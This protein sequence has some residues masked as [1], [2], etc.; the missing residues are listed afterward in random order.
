MAAQNKGARMSPHVVLNREVVKKVLETVDAGLV[1][2][3]GIPVPGK[4]CVEAAVNYALG[5]E[6]NDHPACVSASVR[7]FKIGLNDGPW[8]TDADR[9]NGMR[10]LA[11]AQLGSD[12][13]DQKQFRI[14][15]AIQ[16]VKRILP[17]AF[18]AAASLIP[19]HKNALEAAAVDC[20]VVV[21]L[22]AARAAAR[23]G[24]VVCGTARYDADAYADAY[25]AAAYAAAAAAYAAYAAADADAYAYAGEKAKAAAR[26]KVLTICADIGLEALI[27]Q[28]SP[29]CEW[30]D[31]CQ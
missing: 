18:R 1:Q 8:P 4:M 16:T 14:T 25:A 31:L 17:I 24:R 21:D 11:I 20:E 27:E 3:L 19:V 7:A 13:I 12:K 22:A 10:K 26:I 2:G 30:L 5:G 28:K 9:T 15:V 6:H 29:G 23:A